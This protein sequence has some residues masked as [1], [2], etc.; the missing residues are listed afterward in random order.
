MFREVRNT[1]LAVNPPAFLCDD[2]ISEDIQEPLP[3][4]AFFAGVMGPPGSGKTSLVV[5]FLTE[6]GMYHRAFDHVHLVAPKASMG[7]LK[8]NIWEGHPQD[9]IHNALDVS[10]LA[11]L[12]AL[13]DERRNK[14]PHAETTLM[15]IDDMTVYLRK[16]GVEELLRD[17]VFNRRH[18]RLSILILIQSYMAM[19]PDL[20]KT[21]SHFYM[22]RPKNKKEAE[23]IWEELMFVPK[24]TGEGLLRFVF[25][26]A[27]DFLMGDCGSGQVYRN[28]NEVLINDPGEVAFEESAEDE[29]GEVEDEGAD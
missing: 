20:R 28:F 14:K 17:L 8:E 5:N 19:P 18:Y 6:K 10:T 26:E 7:S 13:V 1:S 15:V 3:N 21:L 9:K 22:F 4:T 27:H 2:A 16:K 24:R 25:R 23:K 11:E 12:K 29:G